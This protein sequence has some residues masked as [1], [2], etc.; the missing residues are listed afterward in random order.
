MT[1]TTTESAAAAAA[2]IARVDAAVALCRMI[3]SPRCSQRAYK[4]MQAQLDQLC[5][6]LNMREEEIASIAILRRGKP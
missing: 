4:R 1:N 2:R 6:N 3:W 5:T